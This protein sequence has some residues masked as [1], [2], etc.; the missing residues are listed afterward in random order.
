MA[1]SYRIFA[2]ISDGIHAALEA[3]VTCGVMAPDGTVVVETAKRHSLAPVAGLEEYRRRCY[4]DTRITRFRCLAAETLAPV[5][6]ID[7]VD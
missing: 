2:D 1:W 5:S 4:G 6:S 3:L 7:S